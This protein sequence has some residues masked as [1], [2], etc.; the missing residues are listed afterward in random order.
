MVFCPGPG[1]LVRGPCDLIPRPITVITTSSRPP[2]MRSADSQAQA[3]GRKCQKVERPTR[4]TATKHTGI[5]PPPP[6]SEV[7]RTAASKPQSLLSIIKSQT[8]SVS[9]ERTSAQSH[10]RAYETRCDEARVKHRPIR[11]QSITFDLTVRGPAPSYSTKADAEL[12][13]I[14]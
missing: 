12:T 6:N 4:S 5:K 7:R 10:L 11:H 14:G 13:F 2:F 9:D 8:R 3:R 1:I